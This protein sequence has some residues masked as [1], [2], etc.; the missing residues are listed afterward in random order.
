[1][2][3][4][5]LDYA[6]GAPVDPE[7]NKAM[8]EFSS[9]NYGNASGIYQEGR[10]AK[11]VLEDARARIAKILS[12]R[13]YEIIFTSGGTEA[14][15]LAIFGVG[16]SF[17]KASKDKHIITSAFEHRSVLEPIK[18]LERWGFEITYLKV[19]RDGFVNPEDV[20]SALRPETI[21]VS[22]MYVNNE[23]GTIQPISEISKIIR[24]F[25]LSGSDPD[26]APGVGSRYP[27]FHTDM[28]QAAG[29]LDLHVEKL[30][31]DL[32]SFSGAKVSGPKG[33]GFLY[34]KEGVALR[35]EIFGG[36]QERG[37]RSG[38]ESVEL[39]VGLA[40]ALEISRE[41][42]DAESKRLLG[43]RDYFAKEILFRIPGAEINGDLIKRISSNLSISF[44]GVESERLIVAL[45][46]KG[47]AVS[48]GSACDSKLPELP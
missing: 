12:V 9:A 21:L 44:P 46:E 41:K 19:S 36:G 18:E 37:F 48:S 39:I 45:D 40:K 6:A 11:K 16:S 15:N 20:R 3:R 47:I 35:P 22:I 29:Y 7:V 4:I 26:R 1:M 23:I 34:K 27:L 43:L 2:K 32:G 5:Y 10:E 13:T 14:N 28:C 33:I 42:K 38:T 24:E 25:R 8:E 17:A 31:V 30:G